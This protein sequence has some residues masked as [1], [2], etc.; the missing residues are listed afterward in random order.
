MSRKDDLSDTLREIT[1]ALKPDYELHPGYT[2]TTIITAGPNHWNEVKDDPSAFG[3]AQDYELLDQGEDTI[4]WPVSRA[5]LQ[6]CYAHFPEHLPRWGSR[7]FKIETKHLP[8]V[9]KAAQR[10]KLMSEQEYTDAM[11]EMNDLSR[12]W[13]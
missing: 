2:P 13:E 9:Q 1:Y 8:L 11:E 4:F 7:G 5:C 10:D 3:P 6:W 12:Q